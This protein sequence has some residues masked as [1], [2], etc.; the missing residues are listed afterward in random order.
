MFW[1]LEQYGNASAVILQDLSAISYQELASKADAFA[2]RLGHGKKLLFV[3]ANNNLESLTAYL[4]CLRSGHVPL[5]LAANIDPE[6]L[7]LLCGTYQPDFLWQL[8]SSGNYE[9]LKQ[10]PSR[11]S[12]LHPGLALL[13]S[14]SG[15]TGSPKLVRLSGMNLNS[16][17]ESIAE[18]LHLTEDEKAITVLPMNYTY[19]LSVINSH[20]AVGAAILLTDDTVIQKEFWDFFKTAGGTSL[21]GVPYTYMIYRRAGVFTKLELPTLRYMTQ[22]GG[23]L[24]AE[25]VEKVATWC[26]THN[27]KFYVMYGQT[28]ATARMSYLPPEKTLEKCASVGIAIPGGRFAIIDENGNEFPEPERVGELVYYGPNVSLGYAETA[29]DL[30]LGDENQGRLATGDMAKYDADHYV[31]ITGRLKRFIKITGNRIGLDDVE[32]TLKEAGIESVCGGKDDLLCIALMN[33]EHEEKLVVDLLNQRLHLHY[34]MCKIKYVVEIPRND[35]GKILYTKL[36]E[37]YL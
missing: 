25:D 10:K 22:A 36:F 27:V 12:G 18:Y 29:E 3:L 1:N 17:A 21:V 14:T 19:G 6:L 5:L 4:A 32:R 2:A 28:E 11:S 7:A 9:L 31:Y 26:R 30:M 34:S 15:S 33:V 16:N 37:E 13:L 23:K 24:P 8:G 35:S 20:L